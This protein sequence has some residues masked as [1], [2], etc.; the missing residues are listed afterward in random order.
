MINIVNQQIQNMK[1]FCFTQYKPTI[2][3]TKITY[4]NKFDINIQHPRQNTIIFKKQDTLETT[5]EYINLNPLV[6]ILADEQQPGG[7]LVSNCQ[8]ETLFRRTTLFAHLDKSKSYPIRDDELILT[9]SVGIITTDLNKS[10]YQI[11]QSN[12]NVILW[13]FLVS[14]I[15][16]LNPINPNFTKYCGIKFV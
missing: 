12:T 2:N 8:E 16:I 14:K 6:L 7:T 5:I 13:L 3:P 9:P 1:W 11:I 10:F 4:N 15:S